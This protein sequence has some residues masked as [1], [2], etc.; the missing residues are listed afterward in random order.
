VAERLN[1]PLY[2]ELSQLP[3]E[4]RAVSLAVPTALHRTVGTSLL[5]SGRDVLVE[6]P[7]ASSVD[8]ADELIAAATGG[9]VLMV[10][11]LERFNP[12]LQRLEGLLRHPLFI[13]S[14]RLAPFTPRGSDVDVVLD[15]MIHDIDIVL[16]IVRAEPVE[17]HAA[18]VPVITP[19]VDIANARIAFADGCVA[20][21]TASRVSAEKLRKVRVF[22]P[23]AYISIDFLRR[24]ADIVRRAPAVAQNAGD[25]AA[26]SLPRLTDGVPAGAASYASPALRLVREE[27]AFEEEEDA[28]ALE[29]DAFLHAVLERGAPPVSG[30]DGRRAL[31]VA[32]KIVDQIRDSAELAY[33]HGRA[34]AGGSPGH[35]GRSAADRTD[36]PVTGSAEEV[37]A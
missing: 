29:I 34:A 8:E 14:H 28:L 4:V 37:G 9:R 10:G 18:G 1:V 11:H 35:L 7:I 30:R 20:N 22:Q 26:A 27:V 13:E 2:T 33:A 6:K 19:S 12:A 31:A 24:S 25:P 32:T 21:I 5:R 17:I 23:D 3:C 15:L 16:N 36:S